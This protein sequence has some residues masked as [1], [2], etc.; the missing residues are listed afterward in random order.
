LTATAQLEEQQRHLQSL[1]MFQRP[2]RPFRRPWP[3]NQSLLFASTSS[4][5]DH[6]A[7]KMC[8]GRVIRAPC[9]RLSILRVESFWPLDP[10]TKRFASGTSRPR[11]PRCNL[12]WNA[13][14]QRQCVSNSTRLIFPTSNGDLIAPSC[15]RVPTIK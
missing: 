13:N 4:R 7:I 9:M 14:G 3:K 15:C 12:R 6:H 8:N 11:Q 5:L 10:L 2:C 1:R